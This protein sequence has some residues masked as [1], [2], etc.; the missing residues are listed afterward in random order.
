MSPTG[1]YGD[2]DAV[3]VISG[4]RI[5]GERYAS[6]WSADRIHDSWSV[7]KSVTH[8]L[9][10]VLQLAG[11]IDVFAPTGI[12]EWAGDERG[13]ITPDMLARMS[14]GL[15]WNEI[16][17]APRIV[18]SLAV[19]NVAS[20][21]IERPLVEPIDTVFNYSTGSTAVNGRLIGDLVGTGDD[22]LQWADEVL[23]GPLGIDDARLQLDRDGYFA[24][25]FG[26]DMTARDFARFGLLYLRDGVWDGRRLLPEGW[27]DRARTPSPAF[28]G[29]GTGF[30]IDAAGPG[31]FAAEGFLGQL[32]AI[33]PDADAVVVV[34]AGHLNGDIS[35]ELATGIV[36]V[37]RGG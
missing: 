5:I 24:A 11:R 26:A 6:D 2:T 17:D 19:S 18:Q 25:G 28:A 12:P 32:V 13:A 3:V 4:G 27:V 36:E 15:E 16:A 1:A 34:L 9:L 20:S 21:Q 31:T 8:A 7:A 29:Y 35:R 23:L 22:F 10:G 14:S 33:V 30:W 37:L